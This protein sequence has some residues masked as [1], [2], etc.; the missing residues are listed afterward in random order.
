ME[1]MASRPAIAAMP[2]RTHRSSAPLHLA[3]PA[4][5]THIRLSPRK[6]FST[7]R[8][9][10]SDAPP[11]SPFQAFI[12]TL[13]EEL[14]KSQDMQDNIRQLSGEAG[15]MQDSETMRRMKEVY[16]RARIVAS[17]K[18]NPRLMKAA[19]QLKRSG[20]HVGEAVNATLKQMEESE[21][22]RGVSR[23]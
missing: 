22:I 14:R 4:R 1:M 7:S 20:G 13:R 11:K 21:L 18:E 8:A 12:D 2:A 15:K 17:L 6:H 5:A 19:D 10:R 3:C 16:E 9:S 23:I